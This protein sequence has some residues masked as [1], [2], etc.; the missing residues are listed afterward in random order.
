MW[1][2]FDDHKEVHTLFKRCCTSLTSFNLAS[3]FTLIHSRRC[4]ASL[5]MSKEFLNLLVRLQGMF[6]LLR[7][8]IS[9]VI[10]SWSHHYYSSSRNGCAPWACLDDYLELFYTISHPYITTL[11][12]VHPCRGLM[13]MAIK[14][15]YCGN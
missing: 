14:A 3:T 2:S 11:A 4:Y 12:Q 10:L 13:S 9:N 8:L 5:V 15:S 7:W 1:T 6:P